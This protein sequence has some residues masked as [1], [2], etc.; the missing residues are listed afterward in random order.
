MNVTHIRELLELAIAGRL[1]FPEVVSALLEEGVE[2]YHAD[3]A[4][5]EVTYYCK[6]GRTHVEPLPVGAGM[7]AEAFSLDG[8]VCAIRSS[9]RG[10]IRYPDFLKKIL[11]AGVACYVVYISGQR[12]LYFS[13][14][15]EFHV[16]DFPGRTRQ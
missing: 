11:Q 16:E 2:S 8:L 10:E 15:G 12:V 13:R 9:Q 5:Q 6:D 1:T 7:V 3:L 14:N 4:R